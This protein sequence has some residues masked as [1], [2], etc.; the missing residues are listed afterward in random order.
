MNAQDIKNH[1]ETTGSRVAFVF[2]DSLF[3]R[4][5]IAR[6]DFGPG[7]EVL[8]YR[9][10][11]FAAKCRIRALGPERRLVVLVAGASPLAPGASPEGFPLLG[12]LM[13]S[14]ECAAET[15]VSFM[16]RKGMDLRDAA[17]I[18]IVSR[19]LGELLSAK[20]EAVFAGLDGAA[21]TTESAVRGLVA[22]H[23]GMREM[24]VWED[25]FAR[26]FAADAETLENPKKAKA[27]FLFDPRNEDLLRETN[28]R[29]AMMFGAEGRMPGGAQF[30]SRG[31]FSDAA[32]RIKYNAI[33]RPLPPAP[34]D[35]YAALRESDAA[36]LDRIDSFLRR[37]AEN[38]RTAESVFGAVGVLARGVR[39][40]AIVAA[41]GATAAY[42]TAA[43]ALPE[44]VVLALASG[45]L[46]ADAAQK[47]EAAERIERSPLADGDSRALAGAAG[48][49]ARFYALRAGIGSFARATAKECLDAYADSWWKLDREYRLALERFGAVAHDERRAA[50]EKA[51]DDFE[52]DA[53]ETMNEMNL[54]WTALL[55]AADG[56]GG[57]E[58]A[59]RQEAFAAEKIDPAVKVAVVVSD[60]LRYEIALEVADRL[61]AE[62]GSVSVEPALARLPTETK[63]T[64]AA[65][66]PHGSVEFE[67]G[68]ELRLDGGKPAV[69]T[70]DREKILQSRFADGRCTTAA[71]LRGMTQAAK[72]ELFKHR[73]VYV[74]HNALDDGGHGAGTGQDAA[75][76]ARE[77]VG[78]LVNLVRNIQN[79]CNVS[80]LWLVAD[81]GF[82]LGDREVPNGEKIPVGES[83]A[84]VEKTTRFY[85]TRSAAALHGIVKFPLPGGL[86]AAMPAG[87]RRFK[88]PG[89]YTFVHGGCSLQELVVPVMHS[90]LLDTIATR[91]REKVGVA[92]LGSDLRVQSSRLRFELLQKNA[93]SAEM[94]ERTVRCVLF[95]GNV[96]ASHEILVKLDSKNAS[97]D[98]RRHTVEL[99]LAGDAPGILTLKVFGVEDALNPLAE[100]TVVNNTLIGRDDW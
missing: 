72:R 79:T 55:G 42:G 60:A 35:P 44:A 12:E 4:E 73:L 56:P 40:E 82:L 100:K 25:V 81:H 63:Y 58:G 10:D 94:Q 23:L 93:V 78:E 31:Y 36:R 65:L 64:K 45:G 62:R 26:L 98:G 21:W 33:A 59:L 14:S 88:A 3:V 5:E 48:A 80:H 87:T 7:V 52:T 86:F 41:Y 71:D 16:N 28:R 67:P 46:S 17:L 66:L 57:V 53:Q 18:G 97:P 68:S 77:V 11:A 90:R 76:K 95:A 37:A 39:E 24:P 75:R 15:P 91:R 32:E 2:E 19:H 22:M 8:E 83:E 51:K 38:G 85:F 13:A 89:G 61:N 27:A 50:L 30:G 29:C 6:A 47:A 70:A 43:W 96:P 49:M 92:I 9:G 1:F 69:T 84:P 99:A 54:A 34:G 74:F 20:G